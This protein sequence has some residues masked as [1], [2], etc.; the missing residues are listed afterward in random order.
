MSVLSIFC[1]GKESCY[2]LQQEYSGSNLFHCLKDGRTVL[3][4]VGWFGGN[5]VNNK[6]HQNYSC[7][8][9]LETDGSQSPR[10]GVQ[11]CVEPRLDI[12]FVRNDLGDFREKEGV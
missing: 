9:V 4:L 3:V 5:Y 12:A 10:L 2:I 11:Q 8:K 6:V 7:D 1:N